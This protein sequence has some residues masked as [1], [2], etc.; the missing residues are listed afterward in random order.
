MRNLRDYGFGDSTDYVRGTPRVMGD[1][2]GPCPNCGCKTFEIQMD[3]E[4]MPLLRGGKGIM[5]YVGCPACPWASLA[6]TAAT[7]PKCTAK[8]GCIDCN[9]PENAAAKRREK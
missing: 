1:G 6:M 4:G 5:T 8:G 9:T 7:T 3:V 2:P